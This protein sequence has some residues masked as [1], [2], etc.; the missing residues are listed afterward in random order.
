MHLLNALKQFQSR[1]NAVKFRGL[2]AIV[3]SIWH[4]NKYDV[5]V[6]SLQLLFQ[7]IQL[8]QTNRLNANHE[9]FW[10]FALFVWIWWISWC[11]NRLDKA[12]TNS[13]RTPRAKIAMWFDDSA[14]THTDIHL[15][16]HTVST[17]RGENIYI[18]PPPPLLVPTTSS[19]LWSPTPSLYFLLILLRIHTRQM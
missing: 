11:C 10:V 12:A 7:Y 15:T 5:N 4:R 17:Q 6:P 2:N 9:S 19:S 16:K 14:P 8:S 1:K 18:S 3:S 13:Q